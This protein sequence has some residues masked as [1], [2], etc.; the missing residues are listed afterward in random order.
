VGKRREDASA[1]KLEVRRAVAHAL[2]VH[3][4]VGKIVRE[5]CATT[6]CSRFCPPYAGSSSASTVIRSS[7]AY[8]WSRTGGA[9][10]TAVQAPIEPFGRRRDQ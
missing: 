4:R 3:R 7:A 8:S 1:A 2:D 9:N 6:L 10:G 5:R